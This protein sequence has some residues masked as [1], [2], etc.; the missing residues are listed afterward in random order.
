ML[1]RFVDF[2]ALAALILQP[3]VGR[4]HGALL[5]AGGLGLEWA[6][7]AWMYRRKL[8]LKL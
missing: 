3:A 1:H 7:L 5:A 4:I 2:D 8:F 6:L